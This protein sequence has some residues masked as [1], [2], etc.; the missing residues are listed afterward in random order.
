MWHHWSWM[1]LVQIMACCWR[2]Q[3][4]TWT[5]IHLSLIRSC[6]IYPRLILHE[7][8][9]ILIIILLCKITQFQ[10]HSCLPWAI[11]LIFEYKPCFLCFLS[12]YA[13]KVYQ[14]PNGHLSYQPNNSLLCWSYFHRGAVH[15]EIRDWLKYG[16]YGSDHSLWQPMMAVGI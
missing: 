16:C 9:I 3:T 5:Y 11:K 15:R 2:H 1:T 10:L 8:L 13:F 14:A 6:G 7:I 4:I 12:Q